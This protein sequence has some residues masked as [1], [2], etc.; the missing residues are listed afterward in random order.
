M[1]RKL[2]SAER[3]LL[4]QGRVGPG[5]APVSPLG[6]GDGEILA[7]ILG[8][9]ADL[10]ALAVTVAAGSGPVAVARVASEEARPAPAPVAE[11]SAP[12]E[13]GNCSTVR[14]AEVLLLR[15]E[16]QEL[17]QNIQETKQEIAALRPPSSH[18]DRLVVVSNELDAVVAATEAATDEIL[19][20]AEQI[21]ALA[22]RILA[23]EV[24][25]HTRQVADEIKEKVIAIFESCNF[26]DITGQR[27]TKVVNTLKYVE[28]RIEAMIEIWGRESFEVLPVRSGHATLEEEDPDAK[29][30]N[31]PQLQAA[32]QEDIDSL[33]N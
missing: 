25:A 19:G 10:K 22:S 1:T 31:G 23:Q 28:Q 12:V 2:Y 5:S 32:S 15:T 4:E 24:D 21:D 18:D 13:K 26:Q 7:A 20:S 16:L 14:E 6:P 8:L 11:N 17:V 33:F 30:L 3:R 29:L 9:K 27:I